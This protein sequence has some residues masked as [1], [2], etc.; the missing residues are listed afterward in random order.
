MTHPPETSGPASATP[1][2]AARRGRPRLAEDT[3]AARRRR[4]TRP[5]V[6]AYLR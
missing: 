4:L 2:C 3:A 1:G 5:L 6:G